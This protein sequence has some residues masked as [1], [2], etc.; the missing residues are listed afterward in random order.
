MFYLFIFESIGT[1]ELIFI[2]LIALIVLGP[3]K[4]PQ[5]ARTIGK[6]MAELRSS[7]YEFKQTWERE[8]SIND[9]KKD[10]ETKLNS[11]SKNPT[12]IENSIGTTV[13]T[14]ENKINSPEIKQ[15]NQEDFEQKFSK[16]K[17]QITTESKIE[18]SSAGKTD[19]L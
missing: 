4:L 7:T 17:V 9:E 10:I 8:I 13:N 12:A 5:M 3:R 2:G 6:T 1:S 14:V 16:M 18:K 11:M 19:W 15:I